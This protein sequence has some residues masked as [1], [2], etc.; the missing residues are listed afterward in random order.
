MCTVFEMS[1][2]FIVAPSCIG[3]AAVIAVIIFFPLGISLQDGHT[4]A[5]I[6][7]VSP[8]L[9][10]EIPRQYMLTGLVTVHGNGVEGVTL[11][12]LDVDTMDIA[13]TAHTMFG[14]AYAFSGVTPG[15]YRYTVEAKSCRR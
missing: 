8:P 7:D 9:A 10:G 2:S 3:A 15:T 13:H 4:N 14:G 12:L 11:V 5:E 6:P 1:D